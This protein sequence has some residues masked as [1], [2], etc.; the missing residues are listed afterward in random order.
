MWWCRTAFILPSVRTTNGSKPKSIYDEYMQSSIPVPV[1][2]IAIIL[3][4]RIEDLQEM[5]RIWGQHMVAL[6]EVVDLLL[7]HAGV[8]RGNLAE[9]LC[10]VEPHF[11][12]DLAEAQLLWACA[13][14]DCKLKPLS[15]AYNLQQEG[16]IFWYVWDNS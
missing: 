6:W 4:R 10:L 12:Q 13:N 2:A 11:L 3:E 7:L 5:A 8:S 9:V 1:T 14:R 16:K 15:G